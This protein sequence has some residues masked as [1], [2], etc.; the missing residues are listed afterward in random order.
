MARIIRPTAFGSP[1]VLSVVE[2]PVPTPSSGEVVV[3][4]KSAG[5]NPI[6]WKLYSGAFHDVDDEHLDS[7]GVDPASLP[8]LG[9]ECAGVVRAIGSDV[10]DV[11]IGD[12]VIVYPVTAAYADYVVVPPSSL[13][14]KP[15]ALGWNEAGALMLAGTTAVHALHAAGVATGDTVLV[16]GGAG[17]VGLMAIQLARTLGAAVVATAAEPNHELLRSLGATPVTYGPGLIDRLRAS[18]VVPITAAVDLVGSD[19]A[20]D[21]S[22]ELVSDRNRIASITGSERRAAAGITLLGYGP[23]EDSGTE[24]RAAAR[25][26]LAERAGSGDL[27]VIIDTTY[28]LDQA[29]RAH[30]AGL[31]GHAP[32]KLI[33]VP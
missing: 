16:H 32:G 17:G 9:L 33:L 22:V 18:A 29:S 7:A 19:E 27:R 23:G 20:L 31:A 2:V 14:E 8:Q 6:D 28:P 24:L 11:N 25:S 5:V 13:V 15:A 26:E 30:E 1:E 4:V 12:E 3:A 10:T 21:T